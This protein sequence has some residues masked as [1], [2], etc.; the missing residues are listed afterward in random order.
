MFRRE[1]KVLTGRKIIGPK[2]KQKFD[3]R[4]PLA[5][6]IAEKKPVFTGQREKA[7]LRPS[8]RMLSSKAV[9]KKEIEGIRVEKEQRGSQSFCSKDQRREQVTETPIPS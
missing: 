8:I 3:R 2:S 4:K 6:H 7:T 9:E 5:G 1:P